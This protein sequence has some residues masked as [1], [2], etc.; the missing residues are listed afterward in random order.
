MEEYVDD[1]TELFDL[2]G[3]IGFCSICQANLEDGERIRAVSKCQHLFH[4]DCLEPWLRANNSCPLCRIDI[5]R[6]TRHIANNYLANI[7]N[8]LEERLQAQRL[9]FRRNL[10]QFIVV[11]G[12]L[13]KFSTAA[14]FNPQYQR[15]CD[16]L[17]RG[18]LTIQDLSS[19]PIQVRNRTSLQRHLTDIR[20]KLYAVNQNR[21]RNLQNWIEYVDLHR[22][23]SEY[24]LANPS[25]H[26]V[27]Q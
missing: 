7:L 24:A 13:K 26:E 18:Q 5:S 11:E 10:F 9:Q 25:F 23:V 12:I 6:N 15:V 2:F 21:P 16:F 3:E 4:A 8:I 17:E 22:I 1:G 20:H 27:W 19:I 14:L